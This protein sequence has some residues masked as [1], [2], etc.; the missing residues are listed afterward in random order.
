MAIL[1][2]ISWDWAAEFAAFALSCKI[3]MKREV[4]LMVCTLL[5]TLFSCETDDNILPPARNIPPKIQPILDQFL[6]EAERRGVP[7]DISKLSFEFQ[8]KIELGPNQGLAVASCSKTELEHLVKID[9]TNTFW[10]LGGVLGQEEVVFHELGHCLLDRR[11]KDLMLNQDDFVSIMRTQGNLSYSSFNQKEIPERAF[12]RDYYLDEL[13]DETTPQP[14]WASNDEPSVPSNEVV[15][16]GFLNDGGLYSMVLDEKDGL[17]LYNQERVWKEVAGGFVEK[18]M[19]MRVN[20]MYRDQG[21]LW[22]AGIKDNRGVVGTYHMEQ[23]IPVYQDDQPFGS[24]TNLTQ[25]I[26]EGQ[27]MWYSTSEGQLLVQQAQNLIEIP[28]LNQS[29]VFQIKPGPENTILVV[30]GLDFLVFRAPDQPPEVFGPANH[31]LPSGFIWD[32]E[33]DHDETIWM[34]MTNSS[35]VQFRLGVGYTIL[36]NHQANIPATRL[37]CISQDSQGIIWIGTSNGIRRWEQEYFS[38]YCQYNNGQSRIS[39][40]QLEV[41]SKGNTWTLGRDA[42]NQQIKLFFRSFGS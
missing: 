38:G 11:H 40:I 8:D 25:F 23:F 5:V 3:I 42:E 28:N 4:Y 17:W 22:V 7:L 35:L 30:K 21:T 36:D 19:D 31:T 1:N 10:I 12:R 20:Y 37:T 34:A 24:L 27:N 32:L 26:I 2:T 16:A 15:S 39:V 18:F 6:L 29:Q 9:T 13:F 41:D 14:C 33:I